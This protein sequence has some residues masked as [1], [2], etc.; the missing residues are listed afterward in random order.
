M[1]V[2]AMPFGI[3]G[4]IFGILAM[5]QAAAASAKIEKL[6]KRLSKAGVLMR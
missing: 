5:S 2:I 4:F 6:K 1:D 3:M